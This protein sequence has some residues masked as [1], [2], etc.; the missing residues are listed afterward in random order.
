[1]G[2]L[3]CEELRDLG[4]EL[5]LGILPAQE[6]GAVFAHL[7]RCPDCREYIG[8]LTAV[9][10]G[11]LALLPDTEP[12]VGF[13][14]RVV[15]RL[16][17]R[18]RGRHRR[19]RRLRTAA[20]AAGIGLAF[21]FGGW[22][23][24]TAIEDAPTSSSAE[25]QTSLMA[26]DFTTDG[27]RVGQVYAHPG[28]PGWLYMSVN[29]YGGGGKITCELERTDGSTVAV[30]SF[31]LKDGYGYWGVPAPVDRDTISGARLVGADGSVVATARFPGH[32]ADQAQFP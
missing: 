5:A 28:S 16:T 11:L 31:T 21:G 1:M 8:R 14:R 27:H 19:T 7:E 18:G 3:T 23:V 10:D 25:R 17:P 29:L 2:N 13:E 9:G 26:A 30:G 22:A 20:A 4:A 32:G 6:R 12:P 15:N 24:G